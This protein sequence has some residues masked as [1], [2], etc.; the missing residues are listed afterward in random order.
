MLSRT[1]LQCVGS[2]SNLKAIMEEVNFCDYFVAKEDVAPAVHGRWIAYEMGDDK[3]Q[4][5]NYYCSVCDR[6]MIGHSD[7]AD[8]PYCHCGAKMDLED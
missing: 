7:P 4:V 1:R 2:K 3:I 5:T 6:K 8:C